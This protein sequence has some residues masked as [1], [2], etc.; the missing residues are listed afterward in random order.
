MG[1]KK[2]DESAMLHL[3]SSTEL[4]KGTIHDLYYLHDNCFDEQNMKLESELLYPI[5]ESAVTSGQM[6]AGNSRNIIFKKP[7]DPFVLAKISS[8]GLRRSLLNMIKNAAE[9][10][11][12]GTGTIEISFEQ[13]NDHAIIKIT[14]NGIG[15]DEKIIKK[16][17]SGDTIKSQKGRGI[18]FNYAKQTIEHFGGKIDIKSELN[19]GTTQIIT[20][21]TLNE[22]PIWFIDKVD[23]SKY[24]SIVVLDD[25]SGIQ[26]IYKDILKNKKVNYF[27]KISDFESYINKDQNSISNTLFI[28]DYSINGIMLTGMDIIKQYGLQ[29]NS[30]LITSMYLDKTLQDQCTENKIK[31]LP[32]SLI[33]Y[34]F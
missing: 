30:I 32:K 13:Q 21:P 1:N 18:G 15:I 9:A 19:K 4:I 23:T 29:N 25:D 17:L 24:T 31:L 28:I 10:T 11:E 12:Y 8:I 2:Y 27:T 33:S 26:G 16:L 6:A 22:K 5:I 20:L 3:K 14:D 34:L 7:V